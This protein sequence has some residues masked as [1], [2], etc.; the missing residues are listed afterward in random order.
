M[1]ADS[2]YGMHYFQPILLL[3]NLYEL[4][5]KIIK[6]K[7]LNLIFYCVTFSLQKVLFK[8]LQEGQRRQRV[9]QSFANDEVPKALHDAPLQ[10]DAQH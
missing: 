7:A 10:I 3:E 2:F 4:L 9:W 5:F 1:N 8:C 6:Y